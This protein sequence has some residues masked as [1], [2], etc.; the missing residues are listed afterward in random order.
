MSTLVRIASGKTEPKFSDI[1]QIAKITG[2]DLN[3]LAY[4]YALD[5]KEEATERKLI[6]SADG[7]TDEETTNAHNFIVWNIRTLEK[8]DILALARQVSALSSYTYSTKMFMKKAVS[9][10]E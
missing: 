10:E 1:I 4:G 6:T 2:A 9:G 8:Q 5:V 3:T 7:Y